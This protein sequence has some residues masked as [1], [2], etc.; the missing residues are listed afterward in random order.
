MELTDKISNYF[1]FK[2]AVWLPSWNRAA[3]AED[4]YTSEI[5]EN[6]KNLFS[7][8]DQVREMFG[9]AVI[10]HVA[11]R[12]ALYNKAVG[13]ATHSSHVLGKA[14]DFHVSGLDCDTVRAIL[15]PELERL[16]LRMEKK[17]GS[18]WVH[19]DTSEPN[20]NRY[21]NP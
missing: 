4:G 2:E 15:E 17:P 16:G 13:G 5:E 3:T 10:V 7:I 9:K 21:F 18:N 19:L 1:T 11:Y 20:P 8:M 6:L 12:P 14:C